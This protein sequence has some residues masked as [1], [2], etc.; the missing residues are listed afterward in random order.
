MV[1]TP[2]QTPVPALDYMGFC[3]LKKGILTIV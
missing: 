2:L 1:Y 3:I